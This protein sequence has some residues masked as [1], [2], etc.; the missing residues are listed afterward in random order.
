MHRLEL[1][2]VGI[3]EEHRVIA[4]A[5]AGIGGRRVENLDTLCEHE[6]VEFVDLR[7]ALKLEGIMM[8]TDAAGAVLVAQSFCV[9]PC[10]PEHRVPV[11]PADDFARLP[12]ALE[13][14]E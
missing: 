9:G 8:K 2:A 14:H 7:G 13:A 12:F 3:E 4:L 5:I 11:V 10:D 6:D 1:E